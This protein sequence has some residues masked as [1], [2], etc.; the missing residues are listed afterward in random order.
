LHLERLQI[1]F[2][3]NAQAI[4]AIIGSSLPPRW[5][6][7][8]LEQLQRQSDKMSE[9]AMELVQTIFCMDHPAVHLAQLSEYKLSQLKW[10]LVN[11]NSCTEPLEVYLR[12]IQATNDVIFILFS[13]PVYTFHHHILL[14]QLVRNSPSVTSIHV[15]HY[16]RVSVI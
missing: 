3:W 5:N 7:T 16:H 4:E 14:N 6:T 2:Q 15:P 12:A 10:L 1:D 11:L 13:A 9:L 8:S